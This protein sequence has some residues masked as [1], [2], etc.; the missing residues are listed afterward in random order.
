MQLKKIPVLLIAISA[1]L[2][3]QTDPPGRVGRL[4]YMNGPVS[5]QPAGVTDWVDA[6]VNRPLTTGD[7]VWVGAG[8]RAEIHVGSTALRLDS[9][10]AFQF[11]NLDDQSIQ[12][13]LSEGNLT[14]R[15]RN[16]AQN[17]NLE[18]DTPSLAFTV[19]RPGEYRIGA[20][21]DSQTTN[22]TVRSGSGEVTSGG[23]TFPVQPSQQ[24]IVV[25][26]DQPT[27]NL[28][29]APGT[30]GWDQWSNSRDLREDRSPSARYV[31][32]EMAGYEDL[33]E[34]G[35]WSNEPGYGQVWRPTRVAADWAPYHDGHWAWVAPWGWT[36]VDNAPWGYAPSHYGRWAS[37]RGS[38]G[39]I[40]G[41]M[42]VTPYYAPAL[43]GW[44]GGG[45]SGFS[46]SF[47]SGNAAAIG[48]FPLGPREPYIP[49]NRVSPAYF[50][51]VNT[52]NTVINNTTIN[53]YYNDTKNSNN[54]ITNVN[55][56]NRNV[57]N[58]VV[59]VPQNTFA[60][61]RPVAQS[62]RAVPAAQLASARFVAVPAI[63]PQQAS[64]LGPKAATMA[65]A[66][67]PPAAV[68]SRPI[69]ART[70]PPP[71]PVAFARQQAALAQSP[72]RPLPPAAVQQMRQSAPAASPQVHVA[73]MAQIQRVQPK[74]G[75]GP[76]RGAPQ[77]IPVAGKPVVPAPQTPNAQ[78]RPSPTPT[79]AANNRP[80]ESPSHPAAGRNPRSSVPV[81][82]T[83]VAPL[84]NPVARQTNTPP[85][86]AA[87]QPGAPPTPAATNRPNQPPSNDMG[88]QNGRP[89]PAVV[90]PAVP[91]PS[92]TARPQNTPQPN[93]VHPPS[94]PQPNVVRPPSAPQ[95]NVVRPPSAPQ[96]NVVRPPSVPQ[97]NVVHP[98]SAPQPNVVH[99]PSAP[100]PNVAHPPAPSR[101]QPEQ[102]NQAVPPGQPNRPQAQA[103]KHQ[104][105]QQS[106][107]D[108][109]TNPAS[110]KGPKDKPDK[111]DPKQ[112]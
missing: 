100:Q 22:V 83:P 21:A 40:P 31:S 50:T 56:V 109:T 94:A 39:W 110:A 96:P 104:P 95:P 88:K 43:V 69:I 28:V 51:R 62:A 3:A 82:A 49:A 91:P 77:A 87:R 16:L 67:R 2:V 14:V 24:A 64:V 8:G 97:P 106:G 11:L 19:L 107:K 6:D 99:P 29:S 74:V 61:G 9:N 73:N 108:P 86:T 101:Q 36:W 15:S 12:I 103:P 44:V 76:Q 57:R 85:P 37:V 30:D 89:V 7:Q 92:T 13:Q 1:A 65:N 46:M 27:Y 58:A 47:S 70:A 42:N 4:S 59:A 63:A 55:Y 48:W 71:P 102:R 60:S 78:Q 33:D 68:L 26:G 84:P 25:G 112:Q 34:N 17:Q 10:T 90:K 80:I 105:P 98:P 54:T 53:N 93:V 75:A 20:N 32:R 79:P 111:Q 45:G 35:Q 5:F 72:G 38:W 23:S 66:P 52:T 41:P 81:V 18:I